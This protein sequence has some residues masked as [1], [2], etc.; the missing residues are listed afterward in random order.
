MI[1]CSQLISISRYMPFVVQTARASAALYCVITY[2]LFT[3]PE[4][5]SYASAA[6]LTHFNNIHREADMIQ[7]FFDLVGRTV[8]AHTDYRTR[9][10]IGWASALQPDP[11]PLIT[12]SLENSLPY[13]RKVDLRIHN[14]STYK[15][16]YV[17]G[18]PIHY[19]DELLD[20]TAVETLAR[21]A[22]KAHVYFRTISAA[23]IAGAQ[24]NRDHF[25]TGATGCDGAACPSHRDTS[26]LAPHN[27]A[28]TLL[29]HDVVLIC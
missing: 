20:V 2:I 23:A 28:A 16:T 1:M 15:R 6:P 27:S 13:P 18:C 25:R 10:T 12:R 14:F 26:T 7:P 8:R 3:L 17:I 21:H 29:Q 19:K 9:L 5:L 11:I 22:G 4:I 24:H